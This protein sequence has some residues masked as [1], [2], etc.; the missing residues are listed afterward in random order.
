MTAAGLALGLGVGVAIFDYGTS[1]GDLAVLG[2]V[3]GLGVGAAQ[4]LVLRDHVGAGLLWIVGIAAL[5]ALGWTITT[6]IGVDVE[7][8]WAVF[9]ASG[10][11]T[12]TVLSG[13]LLWFLTRLNSGRATD[14]ERRDRRGGAA[15]RRAAVV[16]HHVRAARANASTTPPSF[17]GPPRTSSLGSALGERR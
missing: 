11:I 17:A 16:Q 12:V 13:V 8:K 1:V 6:S 14:D 3:S 7:S 2:A 4:W 15:H 9:G 5:W 10:A